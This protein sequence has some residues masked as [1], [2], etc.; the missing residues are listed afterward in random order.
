MIVDD[1]ILDGLF[2]KTGDVFSMSEWSEG[3]VVGWLD[4]W[5]INW[6]DEFEG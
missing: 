2:T 3:W 5:M 4:D 6:R 1:Y